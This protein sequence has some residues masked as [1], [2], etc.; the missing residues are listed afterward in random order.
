MVG[1]TDTLA[2]GTGANRL[3]MYAYKTETGDRQMMVYFPQHKLL[4]TT[5]HY[6]GKNQ[7]GVY[8]NPE[9]VWEVYQS[10]I[11]RKLDV[12]QFYA[13]H[14]RGPIPFDEMVNDVKTGME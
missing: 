3:V 5:D 2:V 6:Q 4:Y 14:S 7:K 13:M 9:I 12:K 10:I 8:W 1:I 11:A